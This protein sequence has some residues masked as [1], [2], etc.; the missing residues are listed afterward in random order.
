MHIPHS[1]KPYL[2]L[3]I[4][5]LTFFGCVSAPIREE[6][7][8][9]SIGGIAYY[10]LISLCNARNVDWQYDTFTKIAV[11]N[12]NSHR[13]NLMVGEDMVLVDGS[14]VY[15]KRPVD[16]H[17][18]ILVVSSVFKG[19]I[20]DSLFKSTSSSARPY[21]AFSRIR[22]VVVDAGHGGTDPGAIGRSGLREK[23]VNLDIAKRLAKLLAQEGI[24][25]VMTRSIDKF[26]PLSS[27]VDIAND[28]GADLFISIHSNANRVRS[29]IGFEVYYV[30]PSVSDSKR[31]LEAA[32]SEELILKDAQFSGSSFDLKTI[33]WDMIYT[34]SRAESI[35]LSRAICR[36]M[37]NNLEAK[38][39]GIKGARFEVLRGI[40]M[41]GVLIESGF[42]SNR[43]EEQMLKNSYYRQKIAQALEQGLLEY[44]QG[45]RIME[46]ASR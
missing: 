25:V 31:A 45:A 8:S 46:V 27:R 24:E 30:A 18:G 38:I 37:N 9:Y 23:D 14:P 16:I 36:A 42:L 21:R 7:P 5:P 26:I 1:K 6:L 11:L 12:K 34:N 33:L 29:L 13:I 10:P 32:K 17:Q 40:R 3:L 20:I 2:L 41:P 28:S 22:K 19:Q 39:L 44:A 43:S 4:L 15:L 35:E